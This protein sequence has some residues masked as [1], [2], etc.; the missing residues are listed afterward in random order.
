MLTEADLVWSR[1]SLTPPAESVREVM[2]RVEGDVV[3]RSTQAHRTRTSF[4]VGKLLSTCLAC[5]VHVQNLVRRRMSDASDRACVCHFHG[6]GL[7]Q[8]LQGL[9]FGSAVKS[10]NISS[11]VN[12][13]KP[14][15]A[16]AN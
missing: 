5:F 3:L 1:E 9:L 16:G 11:N 10:V 6:V 7:E 13:G 15:A 14:R 2:C 12:N 8:R 4:G